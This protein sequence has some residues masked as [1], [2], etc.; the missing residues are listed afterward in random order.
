MKFPAPTPTLDRDGHDVTVLDLESS[1]FRRLPPDFG[2]RSLVGNGVDVDVLR[3]AGIEEADAFAAVTQG[4]NR[5]LMA[6]QI[7]K[8]VF[9]VRQVICR[10]Y[11]PIR[12]DFYKGLGL[13]TISPTTII[14]GMI[15]DM[16]QEGR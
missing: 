1:Q 2:G 4:D 9:N 13:T 15:S 16:L 5:N 14:S 3:R 8:D 7:A 6:A 12:E 11:D 10:I